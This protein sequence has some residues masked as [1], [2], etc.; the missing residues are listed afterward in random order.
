MRV[1]VTNMSPKS[2][3]VLVYDREDDDDDLEERPPRL[4][5]VAAGA[6]IE[7]AISQRGHLVAMGFE[8][9]VEPLPK[10]RKPKKPLR[11]K[12]GPSSTTRLSP[13]TTTTRR[14]ITK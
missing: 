10:R 2:G 4:I 8:A 12:V 9:R 5:S 1:Q 13:S 11:T 7:I 14:P 3:S 6:S